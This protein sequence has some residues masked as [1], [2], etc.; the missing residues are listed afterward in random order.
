MGFLS[1][2]DENL[3]FMVV[4]WGG[5]EPLPLKQGWR[6]AGS[7]AVVQAL[8]GLDS[9]NAFKRPVYSASI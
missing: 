6:R 3:P 7:L 4:G 8:L 9:E 1:Q 2:E 5:G